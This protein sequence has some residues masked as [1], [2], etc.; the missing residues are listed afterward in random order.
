MFVW[1]THDGK[2]FNAKDERSLIEQLRKDTI[3]KSDNID[4]FM[5]MMARWT[6]LYNKTQLNTTNPNTFVQSMLD[7]E[8]LTKWSKN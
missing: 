8:L 7:H 4:D 5:I 1:I 3:V 6:M 2:L